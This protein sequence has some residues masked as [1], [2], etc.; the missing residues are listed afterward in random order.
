[1][2]IPA[3]K[4]IMSFVPESLILFLHDLDGY[5]VDGVLNRKWGKFCHRKA[6]FEMFEK[7]WS[8]KRLQKLERNGTT[9]GTTFIVKKVRFSGDVKCKDVQVVTFYVH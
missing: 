6:L 9:F 1:M 2:Q 5:L 3:F 8:F 4:P 7:D